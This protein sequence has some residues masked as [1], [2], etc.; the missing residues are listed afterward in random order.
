[1]FP[2]KYILYVYFI[3]YRKI[4]LETY[5]RYECTVVDFLIASG[6]SIIC[7]LAYRCITQKPLQFFLDNKETFKKHDETSGSNKSQV[8]YTS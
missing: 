5:H 8:T 1:M 7:F 4:A 3:F 6:M 2:T